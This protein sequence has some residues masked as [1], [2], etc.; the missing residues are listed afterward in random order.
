MRE[1]LEGG[2]KALICRT[3]SSILEGPLVPVGELFSL[4]GINKIISSAHFSVISWITYCFL[5]FFSLVFITIPISKLALLHCT[6][7]VH[8]ILR[9]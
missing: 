5:S 7:Q 1:G 2:R 4:V 8:C 9:N 3:E 6:T